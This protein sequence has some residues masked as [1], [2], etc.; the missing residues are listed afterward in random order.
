VLSNGSP[1]RFT[2]PMRSPC[3]WRGA[4]R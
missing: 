3:R 1:Q 4:D 2:R